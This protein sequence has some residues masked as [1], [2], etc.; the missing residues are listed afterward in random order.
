[1][2][3]SRWEVFLLTWRH[4]A[5]ITGIPA[6]Q[7]RSLWPSYPTGDCRC[8]NVRTHTAPQL[9]TFLIPIS[10]IIL[11]TVISEKRTRTM[12]ISQVMQPDVMMGRSQEVIPSN[13]EA[14]LRRPTCIEKDAHLQ[15]QRTLSILYRSYLVTVV[16]T[17]FIKMLW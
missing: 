13:Q 3:D 17:H 6:S 2:R 16:I 12:S 1:M 4:V 15:Y 14:T 10:P 9:Y 5:Y 8:C 7:D 11:F